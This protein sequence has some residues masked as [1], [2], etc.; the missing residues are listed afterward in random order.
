VYVLAEALL[1]PQDKCGIDA[2][3]FNM[4]VSVLWLVLAACIAV[5]G[6][7]AARVGLSRAH[8]S[9]KPSV[10]EISE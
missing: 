10:A 4:W 9:I 2:C 8:H 5:I 3:S 1:M 6:M 7:L